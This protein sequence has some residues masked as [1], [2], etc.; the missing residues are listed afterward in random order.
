MT[1]ES[2]TMRYRRTKIITIIVGCVCVILLT[3][4]FFINRE[5]T[6]YD[7]VT[8]RYSYEEL[9]AIENLMRE[10]KCSYDE[11]NSKYPIECERDVSY[12]IP[13]GKRISYVG[14]NNEVLPIYFEKDG[15]YCYYDAIVQPVV[16][17][18]ELYKAFYSCENV[19]ELMEIDTEGFY[20]FFYTGDN[21]LVS[22]HYTT[23]GYYIDIYYDDE[24]NMIDIRCNLI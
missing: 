5:K 12:D 13:G 18:F 16:S 21:L 6:I 14:E 10:S 2:N 19:Y 22:T 17:K 4:C 23:D 7:L 20:W 11:L 24:Y 15:T 8:T 9:V 1:A 3:S